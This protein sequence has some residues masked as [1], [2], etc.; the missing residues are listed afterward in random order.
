MSV[1]AIVLAAG[2]S[3]RMNQNKLLMKLDGIEIYKYILNTIKECKDFFNEIIVVG[4][5]SE[6]L[7]YAESLGFKAKSNNNSHLGQSTSI[8]ISL[9][10]LKPADG[11]MFFVSD[12]PYI[13]KETIKKLYDAFNEN[14]DKIIIPSYNGIK[15]NPPIFPHRFKEELLRLSG[16]V[17]GKDVIK[18]HLKEI[19]KVNIHTEKEHIDIDTMD[20]YKKQINRGDFM[21]GEVIVVKSGGDIA[22]GIIQ[23]LH[24]TGFR[25]LVLEIEKPTSIRRTVCFSEAVYGGKIEIEGITSLLAN[26]IQEI[27]DA[28]SKNCI[29]VVVDPEG[30]YINK[31]NPI[32]VVDAIIAKKNTGMKKDAAPVTIAVGPGFEAG[33][34]VHIVIESNRG[35]NLGRLIFSGFAE[36]NTMKPGNVDGFTFDRVLYSPDD[37]NFMANY[38]IGDLVKT[39]DVIG[40][41]NDKSVKAKLDG[42]IRGLIREGIYVAEGQKIGDIDPRNDKEYCYTISDK[43]RAIGGAVLEAV[44]ISINERNSGC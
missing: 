14:K 31:L 26:S 43:A 42:V 18:K 30:I 28:W 32:A 24:R 17:G 15:G 4:K 5:D 2:L 6:V 33:K 39:G 7:Y 41:V 21:K 36:P 44:L 37:G 34:D 10:N 19:V 8:I 20:D 12:Q 3:R 25:V 29:P 27:Y 1:S 23:K 38:K 13:K 40:Y 35:H 22:S 16:D 9:K 11:Y